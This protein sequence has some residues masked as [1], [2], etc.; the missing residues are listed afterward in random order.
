MIKKNLSINYFDFML[1]IYLL[2]ENVLGLAERVDPPLE[3]VV[4]SLGVDHFG[5][6]SSNLLFVVFPVFVDF[7]A[8]VPQ[9]DQL[10]FAIDEFV[11]EG[12]AWKIKSKALNLVITSIQTQNSKRQLKGRN[13]AP[14]YEFCTITFLH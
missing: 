5:L 14:K 4:R 6:Q 9:A 8:F 3:T 11:S 2:L 1:N 7:R 12:V 13:K 10:P